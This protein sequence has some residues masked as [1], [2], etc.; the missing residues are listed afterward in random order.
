MTRTTDE[1]PSLPFEPW[2]ATCE[3]LHLWTQVVG[4]IRL[5][6]APLTNHWWD[7]ALYVTPRGLTTSAIPFDGRDLEITFDFRRHELHFAASDGRD[8]QFPLR[9]FSVA[10]FYEHVMDVLDSLGFQCRIWP[11][12]VELPV[13]IPFREDAV[14]ATYDHEAVERFHR[15]LVAADRVLKTFRA[16]FVGKSSPVHFFWGSFDLAVSRFSGRT[17]PPHPGGIPHLA[18]W[19]SREAYSHETISC[20][21]WPGNGGFGQPAFYAYAY[22]EPPGL[23]EA[24]I[25]PAGASYNAAMREFVLPYD[26]VRQAPD[27]EETALAFLQSTYECAAELAQWDRP[28][29]ERHAP[30]GS[31]SRSPGPR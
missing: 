3:T 28:A 2:Q 10:E 20:G 18:D 15:A 30:I 4:K 9:P 17:A 25:E 27:P 6:R 5:A 13:V 12:P 23:S 29:L 8:A 24:R 14:H 26:I 16:R 31:A 21:W 19:V 1:W 7:V 11:V 22:P